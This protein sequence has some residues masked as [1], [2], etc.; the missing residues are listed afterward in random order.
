MQ[1]EDLGEASRD[2]QAW[3]E[4][5]RTIGRHP[6]G[7]RPLLKA[8][9]AGSAALAI[10]SGTVAGSHGGPH[11]KIDPY[12]G[13]PS[14]E[15]Q[16]ISKVV[17]DAIV[18]DVDLHIGFPQSPED[19]HPPFFHYE[20]AG[21]RVDS[22]DVVR[23]NFTTPDHTITAYHPALG[24]QQRVPAGVPP[25]SSPVGNLGGFWLYRFE[26]EGLYDM[27]C[28]PHEILGMAMRIVVGDDENAGSSYEDDFHPSPPLRGPTSRAEIE[29]ILPLEDPPGWPFLTPV[30]VLGTTV[31]DPSNIIESGAVGWHAVIE[32]LGFEHEG[33][34]H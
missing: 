5:L 2:E 3:K 6:V 1:P 23:F 16:D 34:D 25:F 19:A 13:Y 22:G 11:G 21:L 4:V 12:Y 32:E 30:E 27:F 18:H 9:A 15:P 10:G 14:P 31:L 7:R 8:A 29:A 33:H 17:G 24:W 28:A 20:P 26:V